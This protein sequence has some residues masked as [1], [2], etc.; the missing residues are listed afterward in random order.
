MAE[1]QVVMKYAAKLCETYGGECRKCPA[2]DSKHHSC[3]VW[4]EAIEH[5]YSTPEQAEHIIMNWAAQH[6]EPRYPTWEEWHKANFP[7]ARHD[8]CPIYFMSEKP[9][10]SCGVACAECANTPIPADIA[11][12]LKIKP[13]GEK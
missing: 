5:H 3:M 1:F 2:N 6:P 4:P 9:L 13:I 10:G 8:I 11:A 12:K 7:D